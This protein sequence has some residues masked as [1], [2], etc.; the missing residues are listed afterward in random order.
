MFRDVWRVMEVVGPTYFSN[1]TE[2]HNVES[3]LR[4]V[5]DFVFQLRFQRPVTAS[6]VSGGV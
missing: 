6:F 2:G 3:G 4:S 1:I 5:F